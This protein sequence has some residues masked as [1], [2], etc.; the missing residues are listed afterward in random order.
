[1]MIRVL[2]LTTGEELVGEVTVTDENTHLKNPCI[3]QLVPSRANPEQPMMA[4][5]PYAI[6]V[7]GHKIQIKN[8]HIVWS[9]EPVK[10]V[11]NQ[12]NS[13]F[14]SGIIVK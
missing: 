5:V 2:K 8:S 12:Y 11:Y 4:M 9:G 1:M 3:V 7:D 14:G 6:T 13:M 10:E